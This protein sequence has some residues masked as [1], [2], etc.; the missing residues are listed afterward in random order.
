MKLAHIINPVKVGRQSDLYVAQPVTF[1]SM[2]RSRTFCESTGLQIEIYYTCYPED[3]SV[4]PADFIK[5][6]YLKR[7]VL[8]IKDFLIKR[9]FPILKDILDELYN[10]TDADYLIYTNVDIALMPSF[11]HRVNF[12]HPVRIHPIRIGRP[13]REMGFIRTAFPKG[14]RKYLTQTNA[15]SNDICQSSALEMV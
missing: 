11:K 2:R 5:T 9:K 6:G 15:R 12:R 1:E 10:A 13:C 7:S 14:L 4:A 8:D 3:K